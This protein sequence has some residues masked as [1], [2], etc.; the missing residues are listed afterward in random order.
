MVFLAMIKGLLQRREAAVRD[1]ALDAVRADIKRRWVAL[2]R[3]E[4]KYNVAV[5]QTGS[6]NKDERSS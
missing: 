5:R 2:A 1:D 6:G 4:K 3:L